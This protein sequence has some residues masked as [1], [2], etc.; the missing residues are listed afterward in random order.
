MTLG[1]RG[2]QI[3]WMVVREIVMMTAIG[4]GI[5][6][7]LA[8]AGSGYIRT[9]LFNL[10]PRDPAAMTIAVAALMLCALAAGLVPAR[11]AAAIDPMTAIRHE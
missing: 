11:R 3:V 6:I 8:L 10:E 1:A 9:L 5:G 4:V 7:P 2:S